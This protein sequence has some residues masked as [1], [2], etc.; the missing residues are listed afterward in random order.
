MQQVPQP[1][2]FDERRD[3]PRVEIERRYCI[4]LDLGDGR[5]PIVCA[6]LD[7]SVTG[8]RLELPDNTPAPD[9][10]KVLIGELSHNA[11]IVWRKDA[12]VGV[13]FVDEHH[14]IF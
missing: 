13:D 3:A 6:L 7:F 12:T 11:R 4:R 9:E 2:E 8:M 10:V 5:A 1:V 14:S